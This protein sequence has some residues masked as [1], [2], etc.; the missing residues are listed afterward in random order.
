MSLQSIFVFQVYMATTVL[1]SRTAVSGNH[2]RTKDNVS[3]TP[4][5]LTGASVS[6]AGEAKTVLTSMYVKRTPVSTTARACSLGIVNSGANVQTCF[7]EI[8]ANTG[9]CVVAAHV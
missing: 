9:T 1:P 3:I 5:S 2:A 7:T 8:T 6:L 4:T